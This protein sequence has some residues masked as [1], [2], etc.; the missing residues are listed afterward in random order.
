MYE[1]LK[2]A[3]FNLDDT[4]IKWVK[5][6]FD[7]MDL[8]ARVSHLF[9]LLV[10]DTSQ[11]A[12]EEVIAFQPGGITKFIGQDIH[13]ECQM[14]NNIRDRLMLPPLISGDLEGGGMSILFGT[15]SPN[16]LGLAAL[17]DPEKAEKS[18]EII[19]REASLLGINWTFTPVVDVDDSFR[20]AIVGT[21]SYG[22][23]VKT[24]TELALGNIRAFQSNNIAATAKHW[25]G[26]GQDD[27][28]QH[29]VTSVNPLSMTKWHEKYGALYQDLIGA[30]VLSIMSAHIALPEYMKEKTDN[31]EEWYRPA[32]LN[33]HLNIDLLRGELGFNGLIVSDATP[34]AGVSSWADRATVLAETIENGCDMILFCRQPTEDFAML[35]AAVRDG[36][37]SER[38]IN[39]SVIRILALK[40]AIG[41]HKNTE[42]RS[43][44]NQL[45]Q[46]LRQPDDVAFANELMRKT[47]TLVKE[48]TTT[49]PLCIEKHKRVL[50]FSTGIR[51]SFL[52]Q[53]MPLEVPEM[54]TQQGFDVTVF[55]TGMVIDCRDYDCVL[56]L[57]ADESS[58]LKSRIYI[59]WMGL[60]GGT[61]EAMERHWNTLPS[62]MISFGYPYHLYDAPR[63]PVYIN[64]YCALP[65]VQQAVVDGLVGKLTFN[66]F[67]PVD[68]FCGL[69]QLRH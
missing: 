13:A 43:D 11:E 49:L 60:I 7:A 30:G 35:M 56:Y 63:I 4:A 29:L 1:Q 67:S 9:N 66:D 24:I 42:N 46:Q 31:P 69:E 61:L 65:E 16:Q 52:P 53:P 33:K 15:P 14:L 32:S 38:R 12:L 6:K 50:V 54:L 64:A 2:L 36:K 10:K 47:P 58:L 22:A 62:V 51:H 34:M 3:P 27:R 19:A 26:D 41:L 23:D 18:V 44:A 20:S 37:V 8:N 17:N 21:R 57:L 68:A 45:Q 55:C 48:R 25:P 5:E 39:E 59:N 28:D 40:A